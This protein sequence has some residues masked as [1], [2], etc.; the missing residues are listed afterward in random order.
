MLIQSSVGGILE[1]V[2]THLEK[3]LGGSKE[4]DIKAIVH[5]IFKL[6]FDGILATDVEHVVNEK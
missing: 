4:F 2:D 1:L 6:L 5:G 3:P